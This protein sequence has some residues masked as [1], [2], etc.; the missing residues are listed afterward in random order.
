MKRRDF[1]KTAALGTAAAV[2][3]ARRTVAAETPA[4]SGEMPMRTYGKDGPKLSIIGFPGLVMRRVEQKEGN[5]L[6]AESVE[7]GLNYFDVAPAYG[8]AEIKL[9]PAL[10]PYRKKVFLACKTK[11]RDAEGAK[12]EFERSLKRL[13]TD[14]FDLYQLHV[15]SDVA[16]DVD[17]AFAKGGAMEYLLAQRKAGRIRYL[18][19]SA[20]TE[21]A[22]LAA[23]DRFR[24][25]SVLFPISFA[26]WLKA[27]FGPKV[28]Q[29]AKQQGVTVLAIK[30][31]CRQRWP[32]DDPLRKKYRWW[33]KPVDDPAE[34][35]LAVGFALTQGVTSAIPPA[36]VDI[37][38][39]AL[40]VAPAVR[41]VTAAE[42]A[43]LR[44]LA[45]KVEPLFPHRPRPA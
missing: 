6:V 29:K 15:L 43:A 37:H 3:G 42:V 11:M 8:D 31:L 23:M 19:F 32:K 44:A 16:K 10:Q 38:K 17:P 34:A 9:G 2:L 35:R 45:Q 27:D 25:D 5:R 12:A 22:A 7:R 20:H 1:V 24:F 26:S 36:I 41:P 40:D 14:R 13:R 33:Y 4:K 21:A 39:L 18:G 28:V 30:A